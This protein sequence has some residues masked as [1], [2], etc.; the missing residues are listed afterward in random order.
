MLSLTKK[1]KK[2]RNTNLSLIK[3]VP[4]FLKLFITVFLLSCQKEAAMNSIGCR[5]VAYVI[6]SMPFN[7]KIL[8]TDTAIYWPQVC[9]SELK[10]LLLLPKTEQPICGRPGCYLRLVIWKQW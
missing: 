9:D 3:P 5:S 2:E 4:L 1:V 8:K 6:D 10:R 7:G